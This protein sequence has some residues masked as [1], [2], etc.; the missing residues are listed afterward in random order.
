MGNLWSQFIAMLRSGWRGLRDN[1]R[2]SRFRSW[3]IVGLALSLVLS[4]GMWA[5]MAQNPVELTMMLQATEAQDW[6]PIIADFEASHPDIKLKLVQGPN[7]T[8]LRENLYT[9]SF[10][11]GDVPYDL[12]YMDIVWVPKFAAAGWLMDMSDRISPE[13]EADFLTGDLEGG[14]YK[15]GLY[16]M[17][18]RTDA[19]MLYYRSDLL[20]EAGFDDPETTEDLL[21]QSQALQSQGKVDWGYVWQGQQ[22]E[23]LAAMFV[24]LLQGFGGTWVNPE[25]QEVGLDQP[26]TI[27]AIEF[28]KQTMDEGISPPG[29]TS[30][31]EEE[32]RRLF[33]S[34][35]TL[36]MRNWP[37]AW[38]LGNDDDSP[39]K[40]KFRIKPMVHLPGERSGGCQGGWGL[41]IAKD[42]RHP[43]AAW[44]AVKY[45]TGVEAQKTFM[46]NSGFVP[47]RRSLFED[48]D[49]LSAY[50][51]LPDLYK[52][53][54]NA[55]LRPP[56]PQYAQASDILQRYLSSA[57]TGQMTSEK[58]MKAAAR[59]TRQLLG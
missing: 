39:I 44:E 9:T 4:W 46:L 5:V 25:T 28:L 2:P 11:L 36:F 14:R 43:E 24:E 18:F 6:Q 57:L 15:G 45:F 27:A 7:A 3:A 23:G 59:E 49:L 20:K 17:P 12:I 53:L 40:G 26:E 58:A 48:P 56:I 51:Y 10:L 1:L 13:D 52:V 38:K 35:D 32:A 34:G 41:G 29:V 50:A 37:Y 54:E 21:T 33:E 30:Y 22:Y 19:G 55:A 42:S 8:N 47:S 31:Q 16:R